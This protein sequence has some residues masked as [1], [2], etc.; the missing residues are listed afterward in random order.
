MNI[1]NAHLPHNIFLQARKDAN[2]TDVTAKG[3]QEAKNLMDQYGSSRKI[4]A[5]GDQAVALKQDV[6]AEL[7]AKFG[8]A[9]ELGN[10][11]LAF[12]QEG[13]NFV[14]NWYNT[15]MVD[16]GYDAADKNRDGNIAGDELYNIR[17]IVKVDG[18]G[19]AVLLTPTKEQVHA[20]EQKHNGWVKNIQDQVNKVMFDDQNKDGVITNEEVKQ[21]E[22]I[23]IEFLRMVSS[24]QVLDSNAIDFGLGAPAKQS[25]SLQQK[26]QSLDAKIEQL[27]KQGGVENEQQ[28][29]E[30]MATR[31]TLVVQLQQSGASPS[32]DVKA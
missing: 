8:K 9:K 24:V 31:Q 27:R 3:L 7:E 29:K 17:T 20:E 14:A 21:K 5:F 12:N 15:V 2:V 32:V 1:N 22:G 4:V 11:A 25:A 13:A 16:L 26:L 10:G 6:F 19:D 18:N 23:D 30:L 28:I